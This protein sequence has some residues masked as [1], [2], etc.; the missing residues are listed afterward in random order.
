MRSSYGL[1]SPMGASVRSKT[2]RLA[3]LGPFAGYT[4]A[5][6][7]TALASYA[8]WLL[9][10]AL[11][12]APYLG[13][14]PAVVVSAALG[15]AGPGMAATIF[16]L[17]LVNFVFGHFDIADH[18]ALVRQVVWVVA[19][20]G[21][22]LLAGAQRK[23]R[24][25]ERLKMEQEKE[26]AAHLRV[27]VDELSHRVKNTLAVIQSITVQT[28]RTGSEIDGIRRA[29]EGRLQSLAETHTLLTLSNWESVDLACL[30]ERSVGHLA[31]AG[32]ENFKVSGPK[33][34]LNSKAAL[35]L[36]LVLHELGANAAKYG[37]WSTAR[38]SVTLI[39][40]MADDMLVLEWTEAGLIGLSAPDRKGFGTRLIT[41]SV[42][43][44]LD[45]D[46]AQTW[47]SEGLDYLL[48][49]PVSVAL[50]SAD[51]ANK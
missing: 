36:G 11:S 33:V 29:L 51:P 31:K 18:G 46:A 4:L 1:Q 45:G 47:R 26:A 34:S 32:D 20:I 21:V 6:T 38:G 39:W 9:P 23:A 17:I 14:Y 37:A 22:S 19:S 30:V 8:R 42:E 28:F 27:M 40:R 12:P 7:T 10:A 41:Q 43:Y 3:E 49:I 50:A 2:E 25:L 16:S 35:A 44:D 13:F 15:G 24:M 48:S 5:L